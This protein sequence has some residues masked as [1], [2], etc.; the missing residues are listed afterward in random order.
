MRK[1]HIVGLTLFAVFAFSASAL[2][3]SAFAL[4]TPVFKTGPFTD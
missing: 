3:T 4:E 1:L 2:A